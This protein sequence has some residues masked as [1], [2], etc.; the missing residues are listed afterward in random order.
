[1][2]KEKAYA[3]INLA[4]EVMDEKDGY[5]M[6]NNLMMPIDIYD[7][8]EFEKD[9]NISILNDPFPNDNIITKAA[10]LFF[11]YTKINGGVFI[12]LKKNIPNQAG[13]AGGSTDGAATLRGLNKLYDAKL[14][15][16]E[17]KE[18]GAKLGSDVP[19]FIEEKSALCTGR[20]EKINIIKS[21]IDS[22][23]ILLIK[24]EAGLS[25][26]EVYKNYEYK[27]INKEKELSNLLKALENN[28]FD[29][30]KNNIFNDLGEVA[31]SLNKDMENIFV[32]LSLI[33][34]KVYVSGSGPTMY[35]LDYNDEDLDIIKNMFDASVFIMECRSK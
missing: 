19:F 24:P 4:L 6:V 7:E 21:N 12:K 29:L 20:G 15:N 30:L 33:G 10:K 8:L 1:M 23:K 25:T 18:L 28:D 13:L 34:L 17:L 2:I 5:H 35:I 32:K 9:N 26:K 3:K 22:F 31:L 27:G 14:S 11:E 16:D